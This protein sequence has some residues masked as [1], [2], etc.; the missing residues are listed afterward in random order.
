MVAELSA[1]R[2]PATDKGAVTAALRRHV[3]EMRK[4]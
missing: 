3:P 4:G 2:S 1:L